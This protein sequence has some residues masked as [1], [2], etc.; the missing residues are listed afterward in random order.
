G[1]NLT[2]SGITNGGAIGSTS[3]ATTA[4]ATIG[5][6]LSVTSTINSQT[7]NTNST[8]TNLTLSGTGTIQG[9]GGLT[10]GVPSTTSGKLVIAS[11]TSAFT[12]T[13]QPASLS[14]SRTLTL[15]DAGGIVCTD[16]GNCSGSGASLQ[17]AYTNSAGGT[18]P[19]ILLE[20][21]RKAVTIA[22]AATPITGNLFQIQNN[23]NST[24]Y[25]SVNTS[26]ASTTA[27][28]V[29]GSA[30]IGG[31][32]AVT[33]NITTSG[34]LIEKTVTFTPTT[35]GWYRVATSA[36]SQMG[37]M[38]KATASYD[39][40]K[41]DVEL[42]YTEGGYG[43]GGSIQETRYSSYNSGAIS[44][45]RISNDGANNTYLDVYVS[46]ATTPGPITL[47]GYGP[48]MP[49]FVASPVVGAVAG[50]TNVSTLTL[51]GGF[52]TTSGATFAESAGSVGIGT[53]GPSYKLDVQGGTGIVGQFSGR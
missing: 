12:V 27:L 1:L 9:A 32:L 25:F 26:G 16:S 14:A 13:L 22:D 30:T 20:N 44:Q 23:A 31:T 3:L 33:G 52:H 42:Q 46:T 43:T 50:S 18:T 7:I 8:L 19:M 49:A 41:T 35:V 48:N 51:G 36:A 38:I 4:N 28:A 45:A 11:G 5:G 47:Y 2:S 15:P 29:I 34:L 40:T 17:T 21:T 53:A 6:T 39:N 10:L 37:G 24:Q